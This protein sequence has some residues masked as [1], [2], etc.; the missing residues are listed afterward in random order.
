M[1]NIMTHV[2][3]AAV[4]DYIMFL[5]IFHPKGKKKIKRK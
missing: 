5:E 3:I 1:K 4:L 2:G